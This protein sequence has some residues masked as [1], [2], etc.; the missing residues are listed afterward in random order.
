MPSLVELAVAA[1]QPG[2]EPWPWAAAA[3]LWRFEADR[4]PD[5][6]QLPLHLANLQYN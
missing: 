5:T 3:H 2:D 6:L 1:L 4:F